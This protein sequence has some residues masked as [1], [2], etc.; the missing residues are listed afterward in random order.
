MQF[1]PLAGGILA[2]AS[3]RS[4]MSPCDERET[5]PFDGIDTLVYAES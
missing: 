3:K 2:D 1:A 5:M 4:V